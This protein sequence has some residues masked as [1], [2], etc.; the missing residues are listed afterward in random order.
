M[1]RWYQ[2]VDCLIVYFIL[3]LRL[4][5]F[6]IMVNPRLLHSLISYKPYNLSQLAQDFFVERIA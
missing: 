2:V 1:S 3:I 6:T 5:L 4:V